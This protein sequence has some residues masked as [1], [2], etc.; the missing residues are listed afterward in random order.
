[1]PIDPSIADL[2]W[3]TKPG[4]AGTNLA[5]GAA[6]GS[7]IA[8]SR[9][10][11]A[12]LAQRAQEFQA[13]QELKLRQ[14]PLQMTL[15]QQSADKGALQIE[16]L[17]KAKNDDLE[18]EKAFTG[19]QSVVSD[20]LAAKKTLVDIRGDV[21]DYA[22]KNQ[23]VFLSDKWKPFS[24]NLESLTKEADAVAY[25]KDL[26]AARMDSKLPAGVRIDRL[27]QSAQNDLTAARDPDNLDP[28]LE[29]DALD[30]I[31]SLTAQKQVEADKLQIAKDKNTVAHERIIAEAT[32]TAQMATHD[33]L[34]LKQLGENDKI[35]LASELRGVDDQPNSKMDYAA[36]LKEKKRILAE[37]AAGNVTRNAATAPAAAPGVAATPGGTPIPVPPVSNGEDKTYLLKDGK[38]F[39]VPKEEADKY[40]KSGDGYILSP[41]AQ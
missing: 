39:W 29:K 40:L 5:K 9:E 26:N 22:T 25:H 19:L 1:M 16:Q 27:L 8:R 21:L 13:E 24:S 38:T 2:D 35:A 30:R 10:A 14:L 7:V 31:T 33:Q 41:Y 34:R 37:Y 4:D 15:Q 12:S 32:R 6:V 17:L 3:L 20:G 11:N 18:G 28:I 23:A 36:K